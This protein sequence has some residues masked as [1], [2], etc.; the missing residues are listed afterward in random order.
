MNLIEFLP[1]NQSV[2]YQRKDVKYFR[3]N[4][5]SV[6][7]I[8]NVIFYLYNLLVLTKEKNKK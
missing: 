4:L 1:L 5:L 7:T 6:Y 3:N 2:L 8:E